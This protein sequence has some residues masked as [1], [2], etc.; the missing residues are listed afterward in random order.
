M[1]SLLLC[2]L[3]SMVAAHP[4]K[5]HGG[6]GMAGMAGMDKTSADQS[7]AN[8]G[9]EPDLPEKAKNIIKTR[10]GPYTVQANSMAN[11][12]GLLFKM[13]C[14]NCWIAVSSGR[15]CRFC[16]WTDHLTQQRQCRAA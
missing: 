2:L 3:A 7:A 15:S 10:H 16:A 1:K 6:K 13:P 12:L 9:I 14:T 8:D 11:P 4:Q 5:S